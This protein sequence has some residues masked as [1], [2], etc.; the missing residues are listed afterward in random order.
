MTFD[1][2]Q[3]LRNEFVEDC[4]PQSHSHPDDVCLAHCHAGETKHSGQ[5]MAMLDVKQEHGQHSGD[6]Q[7][8]GVVEMREKV[9]WRKDRYDQRLEG[10][11]NRIHLALQS[12]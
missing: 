8:V 2:R 12:E 3:R 10:G 5:V 9:H 11:L 1:K 7:N 4:L 6:R